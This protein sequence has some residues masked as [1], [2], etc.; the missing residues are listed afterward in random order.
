MKTLERWE[1]K[2]ESEGDKELVDTNWL[3]GCW[4][5]EE[6]LPF[7]KVMGK[8]SDAGRDIGSED[9]KEDGGGARI[10]GQGQRI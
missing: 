4:V 3:I 9:S 7:W 10:D 6:C 5:V 8:E 2:Q 1:I